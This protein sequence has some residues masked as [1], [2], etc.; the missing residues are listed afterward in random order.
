[1]PFE[2]RE[3]IIKATVGEEGKGK[4]N[5]ASSGKMDENG[6]QEIIAACVEQVMDLLRQK[7][8]R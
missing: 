5:T 8:D 1:M 6:K 4:S 3:L 7:N 2:V